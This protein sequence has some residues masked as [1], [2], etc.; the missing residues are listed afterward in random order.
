MELEQ[1]PSSE[2][3]EV[4]ADG[5]SR[6]Y[7]RGW[8]TLARLGE[9]LGTDRQ[10]AIEFVELRGVVGRDGPQSLEEAIEDVRTLNEYRPR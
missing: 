6:S 8:V 7:R 5:A 3:S 4:D 2:A 10:G 9:W 1:H